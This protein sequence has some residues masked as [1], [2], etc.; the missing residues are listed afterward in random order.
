M[1]I[2]VD[3]D[4][5]PRQVRDIIQRASERLLL[6]LVFVA[7]RPIPATKSARLSMIVAEAGPD[8]ADDYIV[9]HAEPGD[10]AITR[11][12]PLAKRLV[13]LDIRVI[14]DRGTVYTAENVGERLSVRNMMLELYRN[15]LMPERTGQ[16]GKRELQDFS[17]ALDRELSKLTR[18]AAAK[19]VR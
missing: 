17:N 8:A 13:D 9:D 18:L 10:L 16:F 6:P 2:W 5:C 1:K 14:N 7:N 4:S 15:G 3:A 11:D 12:I 19:P